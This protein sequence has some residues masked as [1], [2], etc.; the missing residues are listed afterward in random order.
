MPSSACWLL[1]TLCRRYPELNEGALTR[2]RA[3]LVSRRQS[4]PVAARLNLGAVYAPRPRRRAQRRTQE[5]CPARQLHRGRDRPRSISTPA[6]RAA[7]SF[8]VREV[9]DPIR[10]RPA[11]QDVGRQQ[12]RRPQIRPAGNSA[13]PEARPARIFRQSRKRSRPPQTFP[14]RS[15]RLAETDA[16]SK[17]LA[18]GIGGTKKKAEQEAARRAI[19]K[20]ERRR[21]AAPPVDT[22]TGP[23]PTAQSLTEA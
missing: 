13:G 21:D 2:L 18:R 6:S 4:G 22:E 9:V 8:V 19:I 17:A 3:E 14:G 7:R 12:H 20:L 16:G 11:R 23:A 1:K 15:L 5:E 10:C